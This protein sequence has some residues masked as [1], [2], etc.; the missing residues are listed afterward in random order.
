LSSEPLD[1]EAA[2][3][4]RTSPHYKML[5]TGDSFLRR[6]LGATAQDEFAVL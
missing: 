1:V 2:E 5:Q 4:W 3:R 6:R